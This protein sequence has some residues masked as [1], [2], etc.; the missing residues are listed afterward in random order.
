MTSETCR[1]RVGR[2]PGAKLAGP[3]N[4]S[5]RTPFLLDGWIQSRTEKGWLF[6]SDRDA[7]VAAGRH[8]ENVGGFRPIVDLEVPA[9]VVGLGVAIFLAR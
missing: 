3:L 5:R 8:V 6:G 7:G 9:E 4:E 1:V 2:R